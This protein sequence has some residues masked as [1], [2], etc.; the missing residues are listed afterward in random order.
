MDS[1][2]VP[3]KEVLKLDYIWRMYEEREKNV[4]LLDVGLESA[5]NWNWYWYGY[6][7]CDEISLL[8]IV[9]QKKWLLNKIK[10]GF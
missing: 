4:F 10:Y 2:I 8:K 9:D 6:G 5:D 3:Y 1:K 7:S